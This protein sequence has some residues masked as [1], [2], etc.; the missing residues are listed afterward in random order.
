MND[1]LFYKGWEEI[2]EEFIDKHSGIILNEY[3][4]L[5]FFDGSHPSWS[6]ACSK[7][8]HQ[9]TI[10]QRLFTLLKKSQVDKIK[11]ILF[12]YGAGG[13]GKSTALMQ[14]VANIVKN[15]LYDKVFWHTNPNIP[16][17]TDDQ[18]VNKLKR[19]ND[20]YLIVSDEGEKIARE[21]YE[22]HKELQQYGKENIHFLISFRQIDWNAVGANR[23]EWTDHQFIQLKGL[24][25]IQECKSIINSWGAFGDSGLGRFKNVD[26]ET[27]SR[28]LME[29][30]ASE[31]D[32]NEDYDGNVKDG[33]FLGAIYQ[34][35]LGTDLSRHIKATIDKLNSRK[36][37]NTNKNLLDAFKYIVAL[38]SENKFLLTR[39]ILARCLGIS[40]TDLQDNVLSIL[41]EE[42]NYLIDD[43]EII[44]ARHRII[45]DKAREIMT[46]REI[47]GLNMD[48]TQVYVDLCL[49]FYIENRTE[50]IKS[51]D[52]KTEWNLLPRYFFEKGQKKLGFEL[53][54]KLLSYAIDHKI[55][56][57]VL[58]V[59][60]ANLYRSNH[61]DEMASEI[62]NK[63]SLNF[64]IDRAYY[65]EWGTI[66]RRTK[67]FA[68]AVLLSGISLADN[69]PEDEKY[70]TIDKNNLRFMSSLSGLATNLSYL[71][72]ESKEELYKIACGAAVYLGLMCNPDSRAETNL[73][74]NQRKYPAAHENIL[75]V[76]EAVQIIS[77]AV[78]FTKEKLPSSFNLNNFPFLK[79]IKFENYLENKFVK[80]AERLKKF[81]EI[82]TYGATIRKLSKKK[83]D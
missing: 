15:H 42:A 52:I 24:E 54:K 46:N 82:N 58:A 45:A 28:K 9:R 75:S 30:S 19:S 74:E 83:L 18:F 21:I 73:L 32:K 25:N 16:L 34:V 43:S 23:W 2:S 6:I 1:D 79:T 72:E 35:R 39:N 14:L 64:K 4:A 68:L 11:K 20:N 63:N 7:L 49:S 81:N 71:Y 41:S 51:K 69:I 57:P 60:L 27:A 38:H 61:D 55:N 36:I 56:D 29:N 12:L 48:F 3:Q 26:V 33:S 22:V 78:M 31:T 17:I 44:L 59:F 76:K 8:I 13:E 67:Q 65:H 77:K 47:E 37:E 10:V 5:S 50:S 80:E 40:V 53:A 62:L 66:E 70:S